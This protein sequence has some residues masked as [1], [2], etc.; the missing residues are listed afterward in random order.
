[1][2]K[3]TKKTIGGF[4]GSKGISKTE[5]NAMRRKSLVAA[6]ELWKRDF[7]PLHF[8]PQGAAKYGYTPRSGEQG[9]VGQKKF[10]QSYIGK[11]LKA[12]G[13]KRPLVWSGRSEER[14][15][16]TSFKP[17]AQA[18]RVVLRI[19]I[20]APALN[21]RNP[22]TSVN[23]REEITTIT[24]DEVQ[25]MA[26]AY[27]D[28]LAR[29]IRENMQSATVVFGGASSGTFTPSTSGFAGSLSA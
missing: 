4:P 2:L 3:I 12:K 11:K 9:G 21:F 24:P 16:N 10:W 17:I 8:T 19:T 14:S 18:S 27:A 26:R 20:P 29:L 13:H 25:A 6:G 7:L 15:K 22:Y 5:F 28:T 23:M 1:M